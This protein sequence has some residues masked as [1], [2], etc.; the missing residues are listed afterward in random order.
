MTYDLFKDWKRE[1]KKGRGG[2]HDCL[3]QAPKRLNPASCYMLMRSILYNVRI[4]IAAALD[5]GM[6]SGLPENPER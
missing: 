2:P 4:C 6:I 5:R 3:P 1:E